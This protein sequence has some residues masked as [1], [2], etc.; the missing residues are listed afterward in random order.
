MLKVF[1]IIL[2]A[3]TFSSCKTY[4]ASSDFDKKVDYSRFKTFEFYTDSTMKLQ[5]NSLDQSRMIAAVES[6]LKA[7]G[8]KRN[9][10]PDLFV[11]VLKLSK[12]ETRPSAGYIGG[13]Y[14]YDYQTSGFQWRDSQWSL[15]AGIEKKKENT[16]VIDLINPLT[17]DQVWHGELQNIKLENNGNREEMISKA[18]KKILAQYPPDSSI[19]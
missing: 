17:K 12:E 6:E 16:I 10:N 4:Q 14:V 1:T 9:A 18:I 11:N 15:N 2:I 7:K 19:Q 8:L 13:G 5:F 3:V